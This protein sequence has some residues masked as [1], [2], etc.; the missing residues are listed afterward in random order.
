MRQGIG[1][2]TLVVGC[3]LSAMAVADEH[4]YA[5]VGVVA[6]EADVGGGLN[7]SVIAAE[8]KVGTELND[9]LSLEVALV[10]GI[11][12]E[13]LSGYEYS[14]PYG[15][16]AQV[17]PQFKLGETGRA[18]LSLGAHTYKEELEVKATGSQRSNSQDGY[19]FGAGIKLPLGD[20]WRAD[21][22]YKHLTTDIDAVSIGLE[23]RF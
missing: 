4:P 5:G 2:L 3:C 14:L 15:A 19:L 13:T 21:L 12:T 16:Y 1:A 17:V 6:L 23:S 10:T 8:V 9:W 22:A 7:P 11:T 18:Y 20:S